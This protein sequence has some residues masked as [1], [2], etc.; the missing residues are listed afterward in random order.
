MKQKSIY[1]IIISC[2]FLS[3]KKDWLEIKRDKALIVPTSLRDMRLLLT[4]EELTSADNISLVQLSCDDYY[5]PAA[6]YNIG[7]VVERNSYIWNSDIFAGQAVV[8]DWDLSYL[9][10]ETSNVVLDGLE[11]IIR[12]ESNA[13]EWDDVKGSA[14]HL[15]ARAHYN[16]LQTFAK[17]YDPAT[18]DVDPGVP[19]RTSSDV[20]IPTTRA[21]VA[22]VY[23]QVFKDLEASAGLLRSSPAFPRDPSK[24][25]A[26]GWLAR[27]YLAVSNY[28]KALEYSILYS[29][30]HNTLI[31][32]NTLNPASNV[33]MSLYNIEVVQHSEIGTL[34][35]YFINSFHRVKESFR[36]SYHDND[37][38]KIHFFRNR[39][40]GEFGTYGFKGSYTAGSML[41]SGIATDEVYLIM[42]ECKA[43]KNDVSGAMQDLNTLLV[44]RWAVGTFI[45][46]SAATADEAVTKVLTE[47]HKELLFRGLRWSDLRR[48]NKEPNRAITLTRDIGGTIYT[49]P[50]NDPKYVLPIPDYIINASGIQQNPR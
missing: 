3:C 26:Y 38:R 37:L 19:L 9:Q 46:Y 22:K 18:A 4:D 28:D 12:N 36:Q 32:F 45:P 23:E 13:E 48:L 40:T 35:T 39:S 10:I 8:K 30:I 49:L 7:T 2:L 34:Y 33:P 31:D 44:K 11:K 6:N 15:R 41:F 25:S 42:A 20:N 21:S 27:C 14:L 17:P 50:P 1:I 24:A 29:Q 5:M 47:R 16:L 43:R